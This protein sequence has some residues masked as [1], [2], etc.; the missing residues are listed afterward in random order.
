VLKKLKECL[1]AV[2]PDFRRVIIDTA[3]DQRRKRFQACICANG[4]YFEHFSEQTLA[5]NLHFLCIFGSS[6][7]Y[8]VSFY[9]VDA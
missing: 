7:F 2:W 9:C 4:G 1:I 8:R 3:V 5:N 6:G